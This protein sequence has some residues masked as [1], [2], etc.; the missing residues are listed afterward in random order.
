M[1][2]GQL[3]KLERVKEAFRSGLEK[4][5]AAALDE[6]GVGYEYETVKVKY[7]PLAKSHLLHSRHRPAPM[8]FMIECKGFFESKDRTKH[9]NYQGRTPSARHSLRLLSFKSSPLRKASDTT[10]RMWCED[11][12]FKYADKLIPQEWLNECPGTSLAHIIGSRDRSRRRL[13]GPRQRP[14]RRRPQSPRSGRALRRN[15]HPRPVRRQALPRPETV[16]HRL[17]SRR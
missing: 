8:G 1:H 11:N 10:T 12:G 6:L 5:V 2:Y 9:L 15:G 4:R 7:Q 17:P 3:R 16:P 13:L 14:H